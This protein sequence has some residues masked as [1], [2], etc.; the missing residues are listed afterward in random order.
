MP[1]MDDIAD[2]VSNSREIIGHAHY[3]DWAKSD[4]DGAEDAKERLPV[5]EGQH[6]SVLAYTAVLAYTDWG[7]YLQPTVISWNIPGAGPIDR[8]ED[9]E[10]SKEWREEAKAVNA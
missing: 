9:L 5:L 4:M 6:Y 2:R 10:Q 8:F 7:D 3:I 1:E